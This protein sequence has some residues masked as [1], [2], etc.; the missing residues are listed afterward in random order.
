MT[1]FDL[2]LL[3]LILLSTLLA[4]IRGIIR[5]VISLVAW[6]LGIG[7]ALVFSG[8]VGR[9][10]PENLFGTHHLR[11]VVAF[12]GI[13]LAALIIGALLSWILKSGAKAIGLGAVDRLLGGLFGAARGILVAMVIVLVLVSTAMAREPWWQKSVLVPQLLV[14]AELVKAELPPDWTAY[15]DSTL[16]A[17]P[18]VPPAPRG[19]QKV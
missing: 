12:V 18:L 2:L 17:P 7:F 10:L 11:Y 19:P 5:E 6:F 1:G 8:V 13:L 4:L 14:G 3:A 9:Q 16:P 15:L